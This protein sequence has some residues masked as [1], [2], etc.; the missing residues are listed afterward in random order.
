[1]N[2]YSI[3]LRIRA[4][5]YLDSGH[6]YQETSDLFKVTT[7]TLSNWSRLRREKGSLEFKNTPRSP[8]KLRNEDLLDYVRNNP[9]AYLREIAAHFNCGITTVHD[10]LKRLGVKYKK[11]KKYI[12]KETRK[13]ERSLRNS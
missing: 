12:E 1:M 13:G 3:D 6:T 9:D 7:R 10:A 11:N 8:H 5:E 2:V 4:M